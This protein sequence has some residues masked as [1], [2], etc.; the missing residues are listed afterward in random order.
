MTCSGCGS[1]ARP[2]ALRGPAAPPVFVDGIEIA[3]EAIAAEAQ[4]HAADSGPAARATAARA[5]VIRHLLL[6]RAAVIGLV[7]DPETDADGRREVDAEALIR[8]LLAREAEPAVPGRDEC[9]RYWRTHSLAFTAPAI[10][11]ASHILFAAEPDVDAAR[12]RAVAAI[13]DI[14]SSE[15]AF[16][17]LARTVSACPSGALGGALGQVRP[18]D[19][20]PEVEAALVALAPGQITPTPVVSRFGVHVLRLDHRIAPQ[21]V[22][23][24]AVEARIRDRLAARAW[25]TAAARYVAGLARNAKIEGLVLEAQAA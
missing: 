15:A 23:F 11:E 25:T 20:A 24:E 12:A 1:G 13:A 18:G 7:P 22:P 16:R 17:A 10:F 4:N 6:A 8:Q 21:V 3:E 9:Q 14:G 5:L 2:A 19:L